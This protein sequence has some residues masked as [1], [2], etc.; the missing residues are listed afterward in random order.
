M[1][2]G[3]GLGVDKTSTTGEVTAWQGISDLIL[4]YDFSDASSLF[5]NMAGTTAVSANN[6]PI[7][8]ATNL[9]VN[10]LGTALISYDDSGSRPV[11]KTGGTNSKSYAYFDASVSIHGLR[12]GIKTN[13]TVVGGISDSAFSNFT[14]N[15][16]ACT[17]FAVCKQD[18]ED[19]SSG[20]GECLLRLIGDSGDSFDNQ[21]Y[22][23]K[24][25]G[26]GYLN[27]CKISLH[28]GG[29]PSPTSIPT[30]STPLWTTEDR[31]VIGLLNG[32][33]TND[34]KLFIDDGSAIVG[35]VQAAENMA[36]TTAVGDVAVFV[37]T[38]GNMALIPNS[39]TW[40]G[41]IYEIMVFNKTLSDAELTLVKNYINTKY[42]LW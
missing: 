35:T 15:M 11:F 6:D 30:T 21:I 10:G 28:Y 32:T 16:G 31:L 37:G 18:V 12:G 27:D 8:Y 41:R 20:G 14:I 19:I 2:M 9:A 25:G 36:M 17:I 42:A 33:G 38:Y 39:E 7:G 1:V 22:I 4:H 24:D 13:G 34:S 26:G 5:Q 29:T 23:R 3:L 40:G